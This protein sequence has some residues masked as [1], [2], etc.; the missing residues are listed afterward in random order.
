MDRCVSSRA[1]LGPPRHIL[2]MQ[3]T[4]QMLG[5]RLTLHTYVTLIQN[6]LAMVKCIEIDHSTDFNLPF[7]SRSTHLRTGYS[8][9]RNI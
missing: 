7:L 3:S 8:L 1:S 9:A 6:A 2:I 5:M 4:Q